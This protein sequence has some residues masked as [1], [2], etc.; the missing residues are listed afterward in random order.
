MWAFTAS[1]VGAVGGRGQI[2]PEP[3]LRSIIATAT[4]ERNLGVLERIARRRL[5]LH[6]LLEAVDAGLDDP[7]D[8]GGA[9][10]EE[11]RHQPEIGQRLGELARA[12][13]IASFSMSVLSIIPMFLAACPE[14]QSRQ[15]F[16][17]KRWCG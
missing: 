5:A 9:A 3:W 15:P 8:V 2:G 10:V 7:V 4:S 14:P 6:A 11:R 12:C 17:Q 1:D 13:R 16:E